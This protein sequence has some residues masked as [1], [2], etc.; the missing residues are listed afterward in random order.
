MSYKSKHGR[1]AAG[2]R[3][4]RKVARGAAYG[5]LA[6]SAAAGG[7][8]AIGGAA[9]N[10][11]TTPLKV[12]LSADGN[13]SA[14][15]DSNG[16]PVLTLGSTGTYSQVQVDL[17][18]VGDDTAPA[19]PPS[20]KTDNYTAGSPRWVVELANGDYIDGYPLQLGGTAV[21]DFTGAQWQASGTGVS[22]S[23]GAYETYQQALTDAHDPL[24][25]VKVDSAYVVE[26]ADQA[27]S[28]ADT[29]SDLQYDGQALSDG[30]TVTVSPISATSDTV[31][32]AVDV[33]PSGST[34]VS[35]SALTWTVDGLDA[36][37]LQVNSATGEI[38][39]TPTTAGTYPL[40][41]TATNAYGQ[42]AS[43]QFTLTVKAASTTPPPS[44][45]I[46]TAACAWEHLK[47]PAGMVLDVKGQTAK[48][49][50]PLIAYAAKAGDPAAD[51][52][53]VDGAKG[54]NVHQYEYTP[55]G[56][57]STALSHDATLANEAYNADGS[58]KFA[59]S[60][61]TDASG[62]HAVLRPIAPI[63]DEA[64]QWQDFL[65]VNNPSGYNM[66]EPTYGANDTAGAHP[67]ALNDK[68]NGG[69]GS[70]IISYA[71]QGTGNELFTPGS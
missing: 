27:A 26:D 22:D 55:Y 66:L 53:V 48:T 7:V 62:T 18:S 71:A 36:T 64:N 45:A 29:I 68:A 56:D 14:A 51:F 1:P 34:N 35:D 44:T 9:A 16:N 37:G 20:F 24:G 60:A 25:N 5:A 50:A 38:T 70:P 54:T 67:L 61:L 3:A 65:S 42:S 11:G 49:N 33:K 43:Q 52:T 69:N 31:G 47:A 40:T 10:A 46:C 17:S 6:A 39:G 59:V 28:T 12:S 57:R 30:S 15:F 63:T 2:A 32:T 19:T 23:H 13:G 21:D 4:A 8:V 58:A 41:V